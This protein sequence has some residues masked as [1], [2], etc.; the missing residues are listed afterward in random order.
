MCGGRTNQTSWG[1]GADLVGP[2]GRQQADHA[3]GHVRRDFCQRAVLADLGARQAVEAARHAF[4]LAGLDQARQGNGRQALLRQVSRA[5]QG[6]FARKAQD[7]LFVGGC[8]RGVGSLQ[9]CMML[10]KSCQLERVQQ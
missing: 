1:L 10:R 9:G 4:E 8:G 7:L 5:Q 3:L 6:A 2:W